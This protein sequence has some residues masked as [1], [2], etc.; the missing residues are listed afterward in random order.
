MISEKLLFENLEKTDVASIKKSNIIN[1]HKFA[2]DYSD[3]VIQASPV[4]NNTILSYIKLSGKLFMQYPGDDDY[5]DT[6]QEFY[7]Q[8]I[9]QEE[10]LAVIE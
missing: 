9:T 7:D 2:I 10:E 4:I 5:L 8:F 6:Y 3:A 1:L